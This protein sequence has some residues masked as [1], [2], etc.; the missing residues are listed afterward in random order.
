LKTSERTKT[1]VKPLIYTGSDE[2]YGIVLHDP[3]SDSTESQI[4]EY[5][6]D[7]L[8]KLSL[9]KSQIKMLVMRTRMLHKM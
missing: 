3:F 7:Y 1:V 5:K 9:S 2:G 4:E 8:D 6:R